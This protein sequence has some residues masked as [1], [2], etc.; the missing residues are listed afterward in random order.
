MAANDPE[1]ETEV[2]QQEEAGSSRKGQRRQADST[3]WIASNLTRRFGL[4]GGLIWLGILTFGVVSEQ[5]K[6]RLEDSA[7]QRNTKD[8][9]EEKVVT[10]R[11]GLKIADVRIGGGTSVNQG[12]LVIL[13]YRATANGAVFEDTKARGKPIVFR[14][15]SRPFTGGLCK[16][17]EEALSTMRTGGVRK[18]IVPPE[19]GFGDQGTV[20]RPTEHVPTKQGVV[21]PGATLEYELTLVRVSIPPS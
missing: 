2:K 1:L 6:T 4:A 5:I 3:D 21:P 13:D 12:M 9:I 7:E 14:Y 19:L 18:V 20:L 17:V 10:T 16:G 11:S 15:G 8:V